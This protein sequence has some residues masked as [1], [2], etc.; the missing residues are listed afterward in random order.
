MIITLLG[1]PSIGKTSLLNNLIENKYNDVYIPTVC[2]DYKSYRHK[3]KTIKFFDLSGDLKYY[4]LLVSYIKYANV[5]IIC[6]DKSSIKSVAYWLNNI[7][8][9]ND[10]CRVYI[11]GTKYDNNY[12]IDTDE[13]YTYINIWI[14]IYNYTFIGWCSSKLNL[15]KMFNDSSDKT[16]TINDMIK[17]IIQDYISNFTIDNTKINNNVILNKNNKNE[18]CV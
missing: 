13:L 3:N 18:K 10:K 4:E 11:I 8:D 15:C 17:Y 1:N 16:I 9:N 7:K 12:D 14:R 2:F 6:Y 5:C